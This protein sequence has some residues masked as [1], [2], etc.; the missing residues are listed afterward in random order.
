MEQKE[1]GW[2]HARRLVLRNYD[3]K[4]GMEVN[5]FESEKCSKLNSEKLAN[6]T[7]I[8]TF[9]KITFLLISCGKLQWQTCEWIS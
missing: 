8:T 4:L 3:T 5:I 2:I 9:I 1:A 6:S 7:N